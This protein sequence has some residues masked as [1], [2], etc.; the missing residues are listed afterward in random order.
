MNPKE[1]YIE[2]VASLQ[3]NHQQL[4]KRVFQISMLR[5]AVFLG[6]AFAVYMTFQQPTTAGSILVFGVVVFGFLM[7]KHSDFIQKKNIVEK[8]IEI[9]TTE[10][11]LLH[12]TFYTQDHG[13]DFVNGN[14]AYSHDIDLFGEYS[15]FFYLNRTVTQEGR[16]KLAQTL[17]SH[18][19]DSIPSKQEAL[20]ELTKHV[21]W[22]QHFSALASLVRVKDSTKDVGSF[23]T[24]YQTVFSG[25]TRKLPL[26]FSIASLVVIGLTVASILSFT[27]LTLWFFVGLGITGYFFK[28]TQQIYTA[29]GNAK[30][31]FRQYYPLL[32]QIEKIEFASQRLKEQQEKIQVREEKA[33]QIFK[34]FSE[35]LHAFDQ[36]NNIVIAI[37]GNA[38]FLW[39]LRNACR[40]ERWIEQYQKVVHEWFEVVSFFDAH[41]SL[42]NFCFNYPQYQFPE[43]VTD[44]H[45][46]VNAKS[47]G[48]P[49]LN[50]STRIDNDFEIHSGKFFIVTGAN[51]AGKSTFLRTVGLSLIMAN[52]GLPVC[53]KR[54]QYR[55]IKL[56]TSMRTSDSLAQNES[57]FYAELKRLKYIVA[58]MKNEEY[59]I[60][61]DEILKGTNSKDK[62]AGS[63]KFVEKLV[64]FN[65]TGIIAT[66][67]ISLCDLE[68]EYEEI[69]N[70]FFEAEIK[71]DELYFD[72]QL[73]L[74]VCK[75]MNA[76]FLL[77]KM[78]IV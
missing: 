36:R 77:K 66:H 69:D 30:E 22:R 49:L 42:A 29:S 17:S 73:K 64:S 33:S 10:L 75:N 27:I 32:E 11:E 46:V 38:F 65:S 67:D 54:F 39:D 41:N 21:E 45:T 12:G 16:T 40:V 20:K 1:F 57:Y 59:F 44:H 31:T 2:K 56:I 71:D 13:A 47:L 7:V 51:M 58:Q 72:Y 48:H 18:E 9:N 62:A 63:R 26:F 25:V 52:I 6:T 43:V 37:F 14:H 8:K 76:S 24:N 78:D 3:E 70:Y 34:K 61:L 74:G 5:L 50:A 28:R 60:I 53:A 68:A 23:I 35:I 15:F 19:I 55:P 4:K